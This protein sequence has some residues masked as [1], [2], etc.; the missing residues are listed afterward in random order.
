[1][2][3]RQLISDHGDFDGL[4]IDDHTQYLLLAGR[5]GGQQAFGG[6]GA[7]EELQLRGTTNANLGQIRAQSP[8]DFDDV[9]PAVALNPYSIRDRSTSA[10]TA[11]Y[12]GGFL[13]DNKNITFTNS[14][15]VY[16]TLGGKPVIESLVAPS[17]AAF[18]L[19]N[20]LPTLR[21][22][23]AAG[24][25]PLQALILNAGPITENRYTGTKTSPQAIGI[26]FTPQTKASI[27]GAVLNVTNQWGIRCIP[28]YST[29]SGATANLGNIAAVKCLNPTV[30]F[31]Q[32]AAGVETMGNYYGI[33]Y[34]NITFGGN[35]PKVVVRSALAAASNAYF[36]Q[37]NGG[38]QS[39][40]GSG[41][42]FGTGA[43]QIR[44]DNISLFLGAGF[45]VGL[46]WNGTAFEF[47]P[48]IGDDLL[49]FF[50]AGAHQ[51]QSAQFGS[52]SELRMGFEKYAFGQT[53]AVGN[54]VGV[55]VAPARSTQVNGEWSDF[56]LT[57]AGNLTIDDTMGLVAAWTINSISL[58][59]GTGTL[60][61]PVATFNIGGMTTS[62]LGTAL[63]HALR[64][65]GRSTFRG[66]MNFE[67]TTPTALAAD[68]NDYQ[69][70]GIGNSMRQVVRVEASG[71]DR[72]ITGLDRQ[73]INDT[74]Y[75]VNIGATFN[76]VLAHQNASSAAENRIISPTGANLTLGP[77]EYA[78]LWHD[79]TTNR[80][81][82]L[83]T[84]GA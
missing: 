68:A 2:T 77:D 76:I 34:D 40:F 75:V 38:A 67:P 82:I 6:T 21:A 59:S 46:N 20:A 80:W 25:N 28:T 50:S 22:G 74:V 51:M 17:F 56:L 3:A 1:M 69:G 73:Q 43:H 29:V 48:A 61:G 9:V 19:F 14:L 31:L 79:D 64:V 78:F 60:N 52:G 81:R 66:A 62:G 53:G 13:L 63:T 10:I 32:P 41:V 72:T 8:I 47:Q 23:A 49:F 30:A 27:S 15:F 58:T 37:N 24:Q 36:L 83:D 26:N 35:V 12:V 70:Q 11:G 42:I 44:A 18:T 5:A 55:F 54:Q 84:N 33:D 7:S 16:E 45:D 4:T 57:Q 65:T 71:A 39:D